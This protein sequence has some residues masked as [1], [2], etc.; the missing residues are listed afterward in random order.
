MSKTWT[1]ELRNRNVFVSKAPGP[2]SVYAWTKRNGFG[3]T[4]VDYEKTRDNWLDT[5]LHGGVVRW[6]SNGQVPPTDCLNCFEAAGFLFIREAT[7]AAHQR[8]LDKLVA[9]HRAY[10]EAHGY[11]GE[12]RAEMR[13]AFGD[14]AVVV[15]VLTGKRVRL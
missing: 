4:I 7:D 10:R 6:K 13:A 15:D 3:E 2:S 12:E 1:A 5:T 8:D 14:D 11:S 9:G